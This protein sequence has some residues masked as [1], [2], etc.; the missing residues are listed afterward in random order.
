VVER[1]G[2]RALAVRITN[3]GRVGPQG[4]SAVYIGEEGD[5]NL[6]TAVT[7]AID[8]HTC[9]DGEHAYSLKAV[10]F[11][12]VGTAEPTEVLHGC[13]SSERRFTPPG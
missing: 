5:G 9:S 8:P 12:G 1:A 11:V 13:A 7:V 6:Y 2:G 3:S 10:V 4:R